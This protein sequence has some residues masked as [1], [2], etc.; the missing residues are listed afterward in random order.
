MLSIKMS[1]RGT[2][3]NSIE[4]LRKATA[5]RKKNAKPVKMTLSPEAI[6]LLDA[7]AKRHNPPISR[8]EL[9]E[10]IARADKKAIASLVIDD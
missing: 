6:A 5:S 10:R 4:A 8:S 7:A 2:N 1:K 9:V 3:P